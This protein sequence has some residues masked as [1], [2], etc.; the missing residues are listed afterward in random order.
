MG[1][2]FHKLLRGFLDFLKISLRRATRIAFPVTI[3]QA[4]EISRAWEERF[5]KGHSAALAQI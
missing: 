4:D 1:G 3:K 5:L 2:L